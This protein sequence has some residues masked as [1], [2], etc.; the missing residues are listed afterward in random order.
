M[1]VSIVLWLA[2]IGYMLWRGEK[3]AICF[4][5]IPVT[6]IGFSILRNISFERVKSRIFRNMSTVVF[7]NHYV[8]YFSYMWYILPLTTGNVQDG[9]MLVLIF[10]LGLSVLSAYC[11]VRLSD[12]IKALKILF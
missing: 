1:S 9:N 3:P 12:K 4:G 6:V 8:F 2:E 11:I 10:T 5:L 7:G